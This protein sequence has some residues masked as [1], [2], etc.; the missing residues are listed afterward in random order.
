MRPVLRVSAMRDGVL[1]GWKRRPSTAGA[2]TN[3]PWRSTITWLAASVYTHSVLAA[4][5]GITAIAPRSPP[6]G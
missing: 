3:A 4:D 2:A 5:S 1:S 6:A